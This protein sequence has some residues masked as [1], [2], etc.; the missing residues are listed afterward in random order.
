MDDFRVRFG[1]SMD[2]CGDMIL[3]AEDDDDDFW[4]FEMAFKKQGEGFNLSRVKDGEEAIAYLS[5]KG[6]YSDRERHP[7][8]GLI[9]LDIKMPRKNGFEVLEWLR[10]HPQLKGTRAIILSS[11]EEPRDKKRPLNSERVRTLSNR[12]NI[13]STSSWSRESVKPG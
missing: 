12:G 11:S 13:T 3:M 6:A 9:I 2:G 5:G 7:V 8:P 4:F 1:P 10:Q